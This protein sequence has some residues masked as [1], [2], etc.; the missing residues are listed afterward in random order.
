MTQKQIVF[1]QSIKVDNILF[2]SSF[3]KRFGVSIEE[4]CKAETLAKTH[5]HIRLVKEAFS[6]VNCIVMDHVIAFLE[7]CGKDTP[8]NRAAARL[9][10]IDLSHDSA[11]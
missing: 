7:I 6:C 1:E 10:M 3:E 4:F 9:V 2:E 5:A 8:S 11:N